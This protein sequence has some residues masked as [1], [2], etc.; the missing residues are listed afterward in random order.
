MHLTHGVA[1]ENV[2][3]NAID[4]LQK[5]LRDLASMCD[6]MADEFTNKMVAFKAGQG[7]A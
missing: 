7:E 5:G 6:V 1:D 3:G 2:E 4:A